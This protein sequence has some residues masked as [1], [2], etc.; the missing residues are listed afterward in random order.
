MEE[1][2][3]QELDAAFKKAEEA[4]Q[5]MES[6]PKTDTYMQVED[7]SEMANKYLTASARHDLSQKSTTLSVK[8]D[9]GRF[10][11]C[12]YLSTRV[13]QG[14]EE[15]A[16]EYLAKV[17][18]N[19]SQ[20]GMIHSTLAPIS[21]IKLAPQSL[22]LQSAVFCFVL[23]PQESH[24]EVQNLYPEFVQQEGEIGREL[25]DLSPILSPGEF[26]TII[27]TSVFSMSGSVKDSHSIFKEELDQYIAMLP[28]GTRVRTVRQLA[29]TGLSLDY[30][31]KFYNEVLP[32]VKKVEIQYMRACTPI[33]ERLETFNVITG[34]N[35]F[36]KDGNF[37]YK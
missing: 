33:R 24:K 35:Y 6:R 7:L 37:L 26:T 28:K 1:V 20:R 34:M 18:N 13:I 19:L 2:K 10:Y 17:L 12:I 32:N 30:Q 21:S 29:I 3:D 15:R 14:D 11:S 22:T 9:D 16:C 31:V 27:R 23:I 5:E 8:L 25:Y 36:D 4:I